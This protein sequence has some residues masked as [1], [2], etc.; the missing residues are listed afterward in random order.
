[1]PELPDIVTYIHALEERVTD[2][3]LSGVR[4]A[5]PFVLRTVQPTVADIVGR[6]V[7]GLRRLG[8]QI[9]F[10]LEGERFIVLHLMIAGRLHWKEAGAKLNRKMDL[11]AF[12]FNN[13]TLILR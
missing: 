11:S 4:L 12:D 13:G 7:I 1:M 9:V 6:R 10:V 8:K 5:S 2:S 3:E